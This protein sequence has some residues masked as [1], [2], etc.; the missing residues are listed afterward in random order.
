MATILTMQVRRKRANRKHLADLD[1]S[2]TADPGTR[3]RSWDKRILASKIRGDLDGE[4]AQ[5]VR[6]V[7]VGTIKD[8]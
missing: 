6:E 4:Q 3:A 2:N 8:E 5:Q 7:T 1:G